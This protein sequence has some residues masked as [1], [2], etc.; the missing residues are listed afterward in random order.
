MQVHTTA[1]EELGV[2]MLTVTGGTDATS[3]LRLRR[4]FDAATLAGHRRV[5]VDLTALDEVDQLV[6]ETFLEQDE[7]LTAEG[8]WLW[9]VHGGAQLGEALR[10]AGLAARISTSAQRALVSLA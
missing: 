1:D 4:V 5:L 7:R 3:S 8:G 10:M 9:L 2:L 6:A